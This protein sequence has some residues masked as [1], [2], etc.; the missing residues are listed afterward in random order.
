MKFNEILFNVNEIYDS[1]EGE[2]VQQGKLT[3]FVRFAGC[4]LSCSWCDSKYALSVTRETKLMPALEVVKK[5][6][7]RNV[8]LT[9]GEP[10]FRDGIV[11]FI[12]YLCTHGYHVNLETNG[13][14]PIKEL[15]KIGG[16]KN[17]T[18]MMDCK[19]TSSNNRQT[20]KMDNFKRL[21]SW[22][23]VKFVIASEK[24]FD[25]F[26]D[27]WENVI[28]PGYGLLK[29]PQYKVF[30]SSCFQDIYPKDLYALQVSGWERT[31]FKAEYE[32]R[33]K[34]QLQAHKYI[35]PPEQRGV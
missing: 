27:M 32:E 22:D 10:L 26:M 2:G 34:L 29:G 19:S 9:G 17:L 7:Y 25:E 14:L 33:V 20:V 1:I 6:K 13:S 8:T 24:D 23:G 21:K 18:I 35:W 30:L 4:N 12:D 28:A 3:T 31:K 16:R 11:E 15:N 5:L